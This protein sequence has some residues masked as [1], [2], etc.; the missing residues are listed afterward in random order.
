M[1]SFSCLDRR[2]RDPLLSREGLVDELAVAEQLVRALVRIVPDDVVA[3]VHQKPTRC[4]IRTT[5]ARPG[6]CTT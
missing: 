6:S 3:A 4:W 5:W 1:A 2:E